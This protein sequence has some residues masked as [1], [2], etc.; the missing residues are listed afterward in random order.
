LDR[1]RLKT[2]S[3]K[4]SAEI[5]PELKDD[6]MSPTKRVEKGHGEKVVKPKC[7]GFGREPAG[8]EPGV[9]VGDGQL[10]VDEDVWRDG[11]V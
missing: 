4:E 7:L 1:G 9:V 8:A 10:R 3:L 11:E 6:G 5:D 2:S